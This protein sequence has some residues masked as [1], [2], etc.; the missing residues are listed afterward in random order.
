MK[1]FLYYIFVFFI[2]SIFGYGLE[3]IYRRCV[4][5]KW[6][7]P[8][9]LVGPYLPIYG[10]GL[11]TLTIIYY[12]LSKYDIN[13][14]IIIL[15]MGICMILIEFITGLLFLNNGIKLWDYSNERY[16]YRGI[17]CL[18]FSLYWVIICFIY[19][20]FIANRIIVAID[21]FTNNI[22]FSFILGLFIG[23]VIIDFVYSTNILNT[24][25]RYAKDNNF[26]VKY[27]ELKRYIKDIE[28]KGKYSFIF[29]FRQGAN[30][31]KYLS[32]YKSN[33]GKKN[34]F[35]ILKKK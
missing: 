30:L 5:K 11:C 31:K 33:N 4:H 27:E 16:N 23:F 21:W 25:K 18:K 32:L 28:T 10:F 13:S 24:I 3:L 14:I 6:I 7:N 20:Y 26:V 15:L 12:Y 8:G 35:S 17:I 2:G 9:F 19:Y 29:P 1:Y 34:I 22:S